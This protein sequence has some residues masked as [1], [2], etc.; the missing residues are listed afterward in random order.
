[1]RKRAVRWLTLVLALALPGLVAIRLAGWWPCDVACQGGGV[2]QRLAGIDVL[3]GAL[4]AYL[5]LAALTVRTTFWPETSQAGLRVFS[6]ALCGVSAFYLLISAALGVLCPFCLT[7]HGL[8]LVLA[9]LVRAQVWPWL[10]IGLLVTNAAY[11]HGPIRDQVV[12][13]TA[14]MTAAPDAFATAMD[15][16]RSR[17]LASAPLQLDVVL[18]LQ[19]PHC[20]ATWSGLAAAIAPAIQAGRLRMTMRLVERRSEPA[21]RDL[22]RWAFAAAGRSPAAHGRYIISLLG[23]RSGLHA[24][25]LRAAHA[26]ELTGLDDLIGQHPGSVESLVDA[27]Q[28]IIAKLGLRGATPLIVL[29]DRSGQERGRWSGTFDPQQVGAAVGGP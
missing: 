11:H 3:W 12:S 27:D 9:V 1:M 28:A 16:N 2:Y 22:A 13:P 6:G 17:G 23:A 8:M 21:S 24:D 29:S 25:E 5:A 7:I 15:A 20:A 4:V 26:D 14:A 19:C 18:D 10:A